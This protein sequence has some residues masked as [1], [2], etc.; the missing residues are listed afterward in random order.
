[1]CP[2]EPLLDPLIRTPEWCRPTSKTEETSFPS[3]SP[4][5]LRVA[6]G[7]LLRGVERP[8]AGW[9]GVPL[10]THV[11]VGPRIPSLNLTCSFEDLDGVMLAGWVPGH[12]VGGVKLEVGGAGESL[13]LPSPVGGWTVV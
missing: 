2:P 3:H 8:G 11:H 10:S 9:P 4:Q 1:M 13:W 5:C 6:Q 12:F 7:R